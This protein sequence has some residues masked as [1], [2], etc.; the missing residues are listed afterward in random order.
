MSLWE[1]PDRSRVGSLGIN[2]EQ[3]GVKVQILYSTMLYNE[4]EVYLPFKLRKAELQVIDGIVHLGKYKYLPE[5]NTWIP[6][7]WFYRIF[8]KELK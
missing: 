1:A 6:R 5:I 8:L 7:N 2:I 3:N 4:K